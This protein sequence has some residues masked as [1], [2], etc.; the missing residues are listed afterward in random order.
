[1]EHF[2]KVNITY[3][4]PEGD[5]RLIAEASQRRVAVVVKPVSYESSDVRASLLLENVFCMA[6]NY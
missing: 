4:Q 6:D 1:M 5:D 2:H 3:F